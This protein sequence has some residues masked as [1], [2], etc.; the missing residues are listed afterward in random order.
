MAALL[1]LTLVSA[2][3]GGDDSE[4]RTFGAADAHVVTLALELHDGWISGEGQGAPGAPPTYA[5]SIH[6]DL[7]LRVRNAD[8]TTRTLT[9]YGS[10]DATDV[11]T[12]SPPIPPGEEA[13][14]QFHFHDAMSALLRDDA[15]PT[16]TLA[17][18]EARP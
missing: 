10:D 4:L 17:R 16:A 6:T 8:T 15:H 18:I 11:L 13:T 5:I 12:A 3:C 1:M 7:T 2:A 9:L 14:M